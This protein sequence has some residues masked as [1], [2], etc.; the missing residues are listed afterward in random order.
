[1]KLTH[2]G[3]SLWYGT[4][5][6]PAPLGDL[7]SRTE[8]SAVVGVHPANPTNSV[9]IR[10]RVDGGLVQTAPGRHVRVDH[11][12]GSEYFIVPFPPI[13]VGDVVEY[14]PTLSCGG[15]QVP[16]PATGERFPSNFRLAAKAAPA[17]EKKETRPGG[18][19]QLDTAQLDYLAHI[20]VRIDE[21]LFVGETPEGLRVDFFALEG[22]V[23][24]PKLNGR[25]MPRSSDHM[26]VRPDGIG[27]IRV[28]AIIA[29]D[30]GAMLEVEETGSV[31]FG[32][33]GYRR[34]LAHDLPLRSELVIAPRVLTGHPKYLW[35]NRA[36]CLGVGRTRLD[37]LSFHYDLFAVGCRALTAIP[38]T[39]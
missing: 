1:M 6:A 2:D 11:A 4:P 16:S 23:A 19:G 18:L 36:Q 20:K 35:L 9:Q 13:P 3:L 14:C 34:A 5:D 26:F 24:G 33:D 28:R 39:S 22:T 25:V 29:T 10:Y 32:T 27:V 30:D 7:V 37:E 31:D 12:Q 21:P 15:R 17:R 8:A 38:R